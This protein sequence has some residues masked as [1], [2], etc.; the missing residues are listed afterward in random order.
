MIT[1]ILIYFLLGLLG[2]LAHYGK[3]RYKDCTTRDTLYQYIFGNFPY[4][5]YAICAIAWAELSYA[6]MQ[7]G[8]ITL[9]L[10]IGAIS[11]GYGLDSSINLAYDAK[12][13]K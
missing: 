5:I 4:T 3:K 1:N 8:P 2:A 12:P 13:A 7:D 9:Q 6:A 10:V 11:V